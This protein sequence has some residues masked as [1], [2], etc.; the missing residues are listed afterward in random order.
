[1]SHKKMMTVLVGVAV[2]SALAIPA[3]SH[4]Q[5]PAPPA[6]GSSATTL[7]K[8]DQKAVVDMAIA[9]MAEV[10]A[11][12]MAV[13]KTQNAQVKSFAQ[14]MIDDH[15]KALGDVTTLAQ[16]KGVTLPTEVDAPHKA[17]AAKLDKLSGDAFDKAYMADAGV[18]DHTKVHAKLKGF[19]SK[20]KDADVKALAAKML[21]TVDEHLQM[22]KE[23][24]AAKGSKA[25]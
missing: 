1:M 19:A 4:A 15:T 5:T 13:G 18:S 14:K 8:A 23:Q 11:G 17:M 24:S 2:A 7:G 9:N 22:A 21:P 12:K 6:A 16:S 3:V 20:T 10:D 25:K